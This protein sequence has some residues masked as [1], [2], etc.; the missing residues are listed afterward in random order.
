MGNERVLTYQD[1]IKFIS[2][3]LLSARTSFDVGSFFHFTSNIWAY[4]YQHPEYFKAWHIQTICEDIEE[5]L[6]TGLYYC[7]VLPRGHLKSTVLGYALSAWLGLKTGGDSSLLYLSYSEDM[8]A[9]HTSEM[10]KAIRNNSELSK[11]MIDL[12]PTSDSMIK[13]KIPNGLFRI[14]NGGFKTFKRGTHTNLGV[15]VDDPLRDPENP[16]NYTVIRKVEQLFFSEVW[17]IPNENAPIIV[18]GT[19]MLPEDLYAKLKTDERFKYR[20]LPALNPTLEH[21]VLFPE[22]FSEERLLQDKKAHPVSFASEM[23]LQ[24]FLSTQAYFYEDDVTKCEDASLRQLHPDQTYPEL[25]KDY[26][27][28]GFDVG[29]KRHPSHLAVYAVR[30]NILY[31]ICDIFLDGWNYDKQE[32]LLNNVAENWKL[33]RGYFDNTSRELEDR[34]VNDVWKPMVFTMKDKTRMARV[35]EEFITGRK[36]HFIPDERQKSQICSVDINLKAPETPMGHG[37][38]FWSN[39]LAALAFYE[40]ESRGT[41]ELGNISEIFETGQTFQREVKLE[42]VTFSNVV[43]TIPGICPNCKDSGGWIAENKLCLICKYRGG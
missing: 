23:M 31:Q 27:V 41:H 15:I 12:V 4:S 8:S 29:K 19:P 18:M 13:Y 16:L 20:A 35:L 43:E 21:R 38:A 14:L 25:Q 17:H 36:I 5:A 10:K 2:D 30:E 24:P 32:E 22:K 6:A 28:A 26:I 34:H 11:V 7:G 42:K 3:G 39:A 33:D 37:D 1:G 9:Y 40:M